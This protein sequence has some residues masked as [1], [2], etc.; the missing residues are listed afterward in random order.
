MEAELEESKRRREIINE[1]HSTAQ[2][3]SDEET[4]AIAGFRLSEADIFIEERE[5]ELRRLKN[6]IKT[7]QPKKKGSGDDDDNSK[8]GG[9][10]AGTTGDSSEGGPSEGTGGFSGGVEGSSASKV[11]SESPLDFVFEKESLEFPS[12]LDDIE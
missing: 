4:E 10:S 1:I 3:E 9:P 8:R 6:K 7:L 12:F 11:K 5:D 2:D